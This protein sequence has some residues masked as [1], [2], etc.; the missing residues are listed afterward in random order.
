MFAFLKYSILPDEIKNSPFLEPDSDGSA[1]VLIGVIL[2]ITA[3]LLAHETKG[4][5][6]GESANREVV[7]GIRRIAEEYDEI[8]HVN[9][10]LTTHFG[11]EY[12][13]VNLGVS[14]APGAKRERAHAVLD[15]VDARIKK[16]DPRVK[17][18]FIEAL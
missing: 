14:I 17:R 18:V 13:L 11:P 8:S 5:L 3:V 16:A 6:I 10:I 2:A 12:I 9:E 4:L 7:A 1:S 15:E